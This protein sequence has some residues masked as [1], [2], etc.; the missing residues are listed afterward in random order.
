[1]TAGAK[2]TEPREQAL[3]AH[4]SRRARRGRGKASIGLNLTA[5]ID[6]VFLLLLYFLLATSFALN[7][8]AFEL[9]LP[10]PIAGEPADPFQVP[11]PPVS[12]T[13]TSFGDGRGDYRLASDHPA[14]AN[15]VNYDDLFTRVRA[16][17]FD[18]GGYLFAPEQT[19]VLISRPRT[20][21]EHTVG[22][23]NALV[24]ADFERVRLATV[25]EG[26]GG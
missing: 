18:Q 16:G 7:E 1:V 14:L 23:F 13:V 2:Q 5:M 25:R 6:V 12:I 22:A 26:G 8:E 15:M 19:F 11:D 10:D 21:W 17:R 20:R 9:D 4:R 3:V 24:R